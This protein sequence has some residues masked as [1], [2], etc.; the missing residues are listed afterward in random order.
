[1]EYTCDDPSKHR[2]ANISIKENSKKDEMKL[3]WWKISG[4][5]R[6]SGLLL[7]EGLATTC[8]RWGNRIALEGLRGKI[9]S[10]T[11]AFAWH[12]KMRIRHFIFS[13]LY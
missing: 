12:D 13:S 11:W 3:G 5:S 7:K 1:M 4:T 6:V 9:G 8:N 10:T 2:L